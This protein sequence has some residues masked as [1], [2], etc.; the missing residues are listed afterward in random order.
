MFCLT[1]AFLD[2]IILL[3]FRKAV[4]NDIRFYLILKRLRKYY[5]ETKRLFGL[6]KHIQNKFVSFIKGFIVSLDLC[7][8]FFYFFFSVWLGPHVF[9]P[10]RRGNKF[11]VVGVTVRLG[12]KW[13]GGCQSPWVGF[14]DKHLSGRAPLLFS[15][16]NYLQLLILLFI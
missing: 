14:T 2:Q 7:I 8:R 16:T 4:S 5:S 10:G 13:G 15:C 1:I 11:W 6:R 9:L 3:I 12:F